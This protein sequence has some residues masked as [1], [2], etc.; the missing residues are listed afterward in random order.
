MIFFSL[1]PDVTDFGELVDGSED[2]DYRVTFSFYIWTMTTEDW[3]DWI[4]LRG[5]VD[6]ACSLVSLIACIIGLVGVQMKK[7][8]LVYIFSCGVGLYIGMWVADIF[9]FALKTGNFTISSGLAWTLTIVLMIATFSLIYFP[10]CVDSLYLKLRKEKKGEIEQ[11]PE[12][13][14]VLYHTGGLHLRRLKPKLIL[15]SNV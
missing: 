14:N 11:V 9:G 10:I 12:E 13:K 2:M 6:I 8:I 7:P 5:G 4:K 15:V 1:G 3:E